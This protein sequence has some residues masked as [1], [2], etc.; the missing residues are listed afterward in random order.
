MIIFCIKELMIRKYNN[1]IIYIHNM[2]GFDAIFLLKILAELGQIK[3]IIHNG[4]LISINFKFN[5][6]NITFRDSQQILISSLRN[7]AKCFG[8]DV[9]KG[10][11]PYNFVNEN[12]LD[13]NGVIPDFTLFEGIS[14][15]EYDGITSYD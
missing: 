10:Y 5:N 3:P 11:F 14:H 12:N 4:D 8:V 6:Y 9:L 13:Y 2:A 7:L 15:D 1:Y